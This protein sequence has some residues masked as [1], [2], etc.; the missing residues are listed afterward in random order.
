MI[1]KEQVTRRRID[2]NDVVTNV[3][4]IIGSDAL[5]HGCELKTSLEA[6]LPTV[7]VDPVQIEQVLINLIVNA[8]DAMRDT[9]EI[10]TAPFSIGG[11]SAVT[12][13]RARTIISLL[14]LSGMRPPKDC[15][16]PG[17][18]AVL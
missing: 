15:T 16:A 5:L 9:P 4:H 14:Q 12:T 13:A 8:F 18:E 11:P 2:L 10:A 3:V 6:A 17:K 7:E 1:K